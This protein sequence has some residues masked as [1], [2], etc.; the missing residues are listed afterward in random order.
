MTEQIA[1][2]YPEEL[3]RWI[4]EGAA[5]SSMTKGQYVDFLL[6]RGCITYIIRNE[7]EKHGDIEAQRACN[8]AMMGNIGVRMTDSG[9]L[10]AEY[11]RSYRSFAEMDADTQARTRRATGP[12]TTSYTLEDLV[13]AAIDRH[14]DRIERSRSWVFL[15][16][17]QTALAVEV[18]YKEK[19]DSSERYHETLRKIMETRIVFKR[20]EGGKLSFD[21]FRVTE[22]QDRF[23]DDVMVEPEVRAG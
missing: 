19:M 15:H 18:L 20:L 10:Q 8:N 3:H 11:A 2:V 13:L 1:V 14:R 16:L 4:A 7:A 9:A 6:K 12:I 21:L 22:E 5:Q 23:L 17:L